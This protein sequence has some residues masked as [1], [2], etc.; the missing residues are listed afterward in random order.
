MVSDEAKR[1]EIFDEIVALCIMH[2]K[3]TQS[4]DCRDFNHRAALLLERLEDAGFNRLA[5]RAMDLLACCNPK[6]L[7]QCDSVQRA[8]DVLERMRE[9]A[10]EDLER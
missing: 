10:R 1:R 9:L 7:S 4:S 5:D 3:I 2:Q 6:D 8:R